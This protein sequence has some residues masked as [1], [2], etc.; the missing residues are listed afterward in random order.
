[1]A[2]STASTS[3]LVSST[4]QTVDTD[5][6]PP[7]K[8]PKLTHMSKDDSPPTSDDE[9]EEEDDSKPLKTVSIHKMSALDQ[10][11][12]DSTDSQSSG[13]QSPTYAA[14]TSSS[15]HVRSC[16]RFPLLTQGIKQISNPT[17][18]FT[19]V[20]PKNSSVNSS[21]N[22][23]ANPKKEEK[24]EVKGLAALVIHKKKSVNP[25]GIGSSRV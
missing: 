9:D 18:T 16:A 3:L 24:R 1:M 23:S 13:T 11:N 15:A 20:L 8:R 14:T 21:A 12:S 5:L 2:N 4:S 10:L 17:N 7:E 19:N 22:F 25:Q 6:E